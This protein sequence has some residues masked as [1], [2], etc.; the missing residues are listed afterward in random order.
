MTTP[1]KPTFTAANT[2][3]FSLDEIEVMPKT[4]S[5][6]GYVYRQVEVGVWEV[7]HRLVMTSILGRPMRPGES[8]HHKN[9]KRSDNQ[10]GNLEAWASSHPSGQRVS[11]RKRRDPHCGVPI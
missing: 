4:I 9:G 11:N 7:E 8:V 1:R 2:R 3:V 10:P 5:K 6:A